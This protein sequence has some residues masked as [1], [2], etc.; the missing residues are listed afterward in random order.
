MIGRA[1]QAVLL[2]AVLGAAAPARAA[3]LEELSKYLGFIEGFQYVF[4]FCQ[5]EADLP[6]KD[7]QYARDHISE[8]RALIFAG[9]SERQR[10]RISEGALGKKAEMLQGF[11]KYIAKET[12]DKTLPELCRT[13]EFFG[14][15]INS[16]TRAQEREITAIV[17]AKK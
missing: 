2:A 10:S 5:A 15:I 12:P 3:D 11:M 13:D 8:R 4:E 9:L 14:G 17:K 1:S 16:E 7:I 6:D